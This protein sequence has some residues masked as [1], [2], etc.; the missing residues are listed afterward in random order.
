LSDLVKIPPLCGSVGYAGIKLQASVGDSN[1][2]VSR[3]NRVGISVAENAF[4][5][6]EKR[7]ANYEIV[8]NRVDRQENILAGVLSFDEWLVRNHAS[9]NPVLLLCR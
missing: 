1:K 3:I 7:D 2:R 4:P 6:K 5:P 9:M 8:I